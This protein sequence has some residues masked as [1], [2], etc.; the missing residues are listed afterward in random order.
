MDLNTSC[1]RLTGKL[2]KENL[3]KEENKIKGVDTETYNIL[4]I[5]VMLL[6]STFMITKGT[7][8]IQLQNIIE[9]THTQDSTGIDLVHNML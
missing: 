2:D 8:A 7:S 6:K 3:L 4:V 9:S 5:C 1:V